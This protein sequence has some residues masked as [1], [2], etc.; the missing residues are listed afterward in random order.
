MSTALRSNGESGLRARGI[1]PSRVDDSKPYTPEQE[2]EKFCCWSGESI[3]V[4]PKDSSQELAKSM[5]KRF[6]MLSSRRTSWSEIARLHRSKFQQ[7][8]EIELARPSIRLPKGKLFVSVTEREQFHA[9]KDKV[10]DCV[11]TRLREFLDGPG[12]RRGVKVYYLKPLCVE[13]EDQLIFTTREEIDQAVQQIQ[14]EVF[15]EYWW[16]Y[17]YRRP[18][19]WAEQAVSLG[20]RVP[21]AC[22]R[23][24][25]DRRQRAIDKYQAHLEFKRRRTALRAARLHRACRTDGCT[26]DEMLAL[27]NPLERIDVIEQFGIERNLS[28]A[29]RRRMM[30][31]AVQGLPWFITLSIGLQLLSS[32]SL[33]LA[34]PLVVCDPAF[35]AEMPEAPG[36]LLK[37][38]HFDVVG[39]VTH[40]EI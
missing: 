36:V 26:F 28:T 14:S 21:R 40:I 12:R 27:T 1:A 35:A 24:F 23:Y 15:F 37:I 33:S 16:M 5:L 8:R 13:I 20:L 17:P 19:H 10:P 18:V 32:V 25:A 31:T 2:L 29:Q 34:P 11:G 3:W 30:K 38:G 22:L 39:G 4:P 6:G 7:V 9:I